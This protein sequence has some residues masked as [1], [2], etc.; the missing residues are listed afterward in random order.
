MSNH[1]SVPIDFSRITIQ[2]L[3]RDNANH[4]RTMLFRAG[5]A[6]LCVSALIYGGNKM[7]TA[8]APNRLPAVE[9]PVESNEIAPIQE[10]PPECAPPKP[11][12]IAAVE[13]LFAQEPQ[14]FEFPDQ[15]S[16]DTKTD[17]ATFYY[18]TIPSE[19][20]L[21]LHDSDSLYDLDLYTKD[22]PSFEDVLKHTRAFL[23]QYGVDIQVMTKQEA[24]KHD[25]LAS[26]LPTKAELETFESKSAVL[27]IAEGIS[28]IPVEYVR[29]VGLKHIWLVTQGD[30][31]A[32]YA[33]TSGPHDTIVESID[34]TGTMGSEL[35]AHEFEHLA[36][37]SQCGGADQAENDPAYSDL[38]G[39]V[40]YD[41]EMAD[42]I[43]RQMQ[44]SRPL[45]FQEVELKTRDYIATP[46]SL[47]P[48]KVARN[49]ERDMKVYTPY[50]YTNAV[51]DKAELGK[52]LFGRYNYRILLDKRFP[53]IRQKALT[54]LA[55]IYEQNPNVVRY[56]AAVA[57]RPAATDPFCEP[58]A[59]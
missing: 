44:K 51:E 19:F 23:R 5:V 20:G 49:F 37:A 45:S 13:A 52:N 29:Q 57:D 17:Y 30:G 3:P 54:I 10:L 18:K 14:Q 22:A 38:N 25:G 36:D 39:N 11:S 4:R 16:P 12:D 56:Y 27:A 9:V 6:G 7:P 47:M 40:L 59:K 26:S 50:G 28:Q 15:W 42:F 46:S 8:T 2:E 35:I 34:Q 55:R 58:S 31:F 24:L 33:E 32:A 48:C 53:A 21:T 1:E 41:Q 43:P